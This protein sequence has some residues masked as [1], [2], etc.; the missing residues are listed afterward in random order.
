MDHEGSLVI[1]KRIG[2]SPRTMRRSF[3]NCDGA[4]I[5]IG[6][7]DQQ[8]PAALFDGLDIM[9][10]AEMKRLKSSKGDSRGR[11]GCGEEITAFEN[12]VQPTISTRPESFTSPTCTQP[13]SNR[14]AA[15]L[16]VAATRS[17]PFVCGSTNTS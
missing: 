14:S 3:M 12:E 11:R 9:Q 2:I 13:D 7:S 8:S 5:R 6:D 10:V 17:P 4:R 1:G 16:E 15:R